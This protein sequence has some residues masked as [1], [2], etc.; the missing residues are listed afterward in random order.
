[1]SEDDSN[2]ENPDDFPNFDEL[3]GSFM[4][5]TSLWPVLVVVMGSAGAFGAALLILTGVDHNPFAAAALL[6]IFGMSVDVFVQARRK[7]V[8]RNLV[9][10]IG[11][12]WCAAIALAGL[13]IWTGIAF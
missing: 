8:Y 9:R 10:L 4:Q 5:E 7:A 13:A 2:E 1:M 11:L 12:I 3:I 6:L